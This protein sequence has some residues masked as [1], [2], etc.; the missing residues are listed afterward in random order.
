M[1]KLLAGLS[2]GFGAAA[3]SLLLGWLGALERPELW[4]YD[5]RV[6]RAADPA[7]VNRDVVFVEF[8]D[9]TIRDLAPH[10]G[11]WPWPRIVYSTFL[12]Y[13]NRAPAKVIAVD[14][15]FLEPDG[16]LGAKIGEATFTAQES[17]AALVES[18]KASRSVVL[19]ADAVYEGTVTG[20]QAMRPA[21]WRGRTPSYRLGPAI[22]ERPL[23]VPPF[24][25]L[26]DAATALGH[27][28]LALDPD[29]GARRMAPFVRSGEHYL[30]SLGIAAA[31]LALDVRPDE[32]RLDPTA[33]RIRD[34]AI[35]LVP[36]TVHDAS[37][38][39]PTHQQ[40]TMMIPYRAPALIKG[41]RPYKSYEARH[42]FESEQQILRGDKPLVDPAVFKNKIVF[43]GLTASGLVDVFQSPFG[44][45][46]KMP[47]IQLHASMADAV[48]T[49]RF[50]RPASRWFGVALAIGSAVLVALMTALLPLAAAV[51]A[52]ILTLGM[53]S[54][55]ALSEFRAGLWV[56]MAQPLSAMAVALFAG[57]AYQYFVEGAEKRVVKRLFGRYVSRDVYQQ[58]LSNPSLAELG[59][60]RREMSVLFSDIRGF[61]AVTEKGEPEALVSQLN[62]YFSRMV[63]IVFRHH[64]T[65]DKF[66]GDMVM[67]LFGAPVDDDAHA[68]HAVAAAVE[69][70]HA[71]G[72]LNRTWGL[73]GRPQLDIGIGINSGTMIAGNIGSS[74]IMSYTAIGDN[75]NLASR[76]ESLNKDYRT[77]IIVSEATRARL[78]GQYEVRSLGDVIVKGKTRPVAIFSIEVPSPLP[79]ETEG[80][81]I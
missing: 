81:K 44:S 6:R 41:Q 30:P 42:L 17:D 67:A 70:V 62:E 46:G 49:N 37:D 79:V 47:G 51:A 63:E 74:A 29:G 55:Y 69:M 5:W 9:T 7:S 20:D 48:I 66:V 31:L 32:V 23:I 58:L 59:G 21:E 8:N 15:A 68:E 34:R 73:E 38:G 71:L 61:T 16:T 54:W 14:L 40:L 10:V 3:L 4:T 26:T 1:K 57:T 13:L 76:L 24:Q 60:A 50:I 27:N 36:V 80:A 2:L 35:P 45:A 75:V 28:R 56:E 43:L 25:A 18:V 52:A 64:G 53:F 22:E 72:E 65:V 77:R 78:S 12:D 19:L 33:I 39:A 11:R